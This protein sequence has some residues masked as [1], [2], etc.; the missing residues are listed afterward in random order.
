MPTPGGRGR[1]V[2]AAPPGGFATSAPTSAV[3][4]TMLRVSA[5]PVAQSGLNPLVTAANP[6][7]NLV[8]RLRT[9]LQHPDPAVLRE[10][11]AQA[12]NRFDSE[13]RAAGVANEK[14][15][16]ARYALCTLLDESA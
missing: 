9:T 16:A 5:E 11:L 4:P 13:A 8:P 14:V 12:L 15:I 7:L 6:L 10:Q 2:P 3:P 1:P